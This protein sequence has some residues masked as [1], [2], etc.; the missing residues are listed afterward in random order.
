MDRKTYWLPTPHLQCV[1]RQKCRN[2]EYIIAVDASPIAMPVLSSEEAPVYARSTSTSQLRSVREARYHLYDDALWSPVF[3][4]Q[5]PLKIDD[6]ARYILADVGGRLDDLN[7]GKTNV[8]I[9][10][11]ERPYL[12]GGLRASEG[13]GF[14][15]ATRLLDT[16]AG[17]I[18][19]TI[20]AHTD[21]AQKVISDFLANLIVI[22]D[23][24]FRRSPEP[25]LTLGFSPLGIR[26]MER[27][28]T[29]DKENQ[30]RR[31]S[32]HHKDFHQPWL[33]FSLHQLDFARMVAS[34]MSA[35]NPIGA[36]TTQAENELVISEAFL[37]SDGP[38]GCGNAH[39]MIRR[40]R[41]LVEAADQVIG[42]MSDDAVSAYIS[43]RRTLAQLA[44]TETPAVARALGD[45]GERRIS[46]EIR[47]FCALVAREPIRDRSPCEAPFRE[48]AFICDLRET[49]FG[50]DLD[51]ELADLMI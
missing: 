51:P 36:A 43:L 37:M 13:E 41:A 35:R 11:P 3:A 22:D 8:S 47:Q 38:F 30:R 48:A 18:R 39:Q 32:P 4:R 50:P 5:E 46:S 40:A 27:R 9:F 33:D 17:G 25:T 28:A 20:E 6:L 24:V 2:P 49:L 10:A 34:R 31:A 45:D 14:P 42:T 1:I 16:S 26:I 23:T 29:L 19:D 21:E 7:A 44:P 12:A 15:K